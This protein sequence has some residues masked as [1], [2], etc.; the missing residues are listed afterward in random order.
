MSRTLSA[1]L[2]LCALLLA[3]CASPSPDAPSRP[4]RFPADTLSFTNG[5]RWAY[6]LDPA[7]GAQEHVRRADPPPYTLHCFPMARLAKEFFLHAR[8][9][10]E[11]P[12]PDDAAL[13]RAVREVVSRGPRG[14]GAGGAP[15][16]VTGYADL[17]ALSAARGEVLRAEAGGVWASYLQRGN[18][19]MVLPFTRRQREREAVRVAGE[20]RSGRV[21]VL[22]LVT[23]PSLRLNHAVLAFGVRTVADGLEFEAYDPNRPGIPL[24]IRYREG[25]AEFRMPPTDYF[26]GGPVKAY[27][28]Y[29]GWDR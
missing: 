11:G 16:V 13:R 28:V 5:T 10:P 2:A 25:A 3:G 21:A 14:P 18:W 27:E 15:V 19:R 26:V 22:H 12:V 4:F 17:W 8:F 7:T 20:I 1:L 9:D 6:R 29:R 23:F 24:V